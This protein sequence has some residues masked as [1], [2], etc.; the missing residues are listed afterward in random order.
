LLDRWLGESPRIRVIDEASVALVREQVRR[1]A[2]A[3]SLSKAVT[4]AAV[5]LASEL[6]HNQLAHARGGEMTIRR[7]ERAGLAGLEVIAGDRGPGIASPTEALEGTSRTVQG[8]H[9]RPGLGVGLQAVLEL[10]DETDFDV[11]IGEGTCIWARKFAERSFRRR[12]Q[13]GIYGRPYPEEE[14]SGDDGV[15]LRRDDTL[16]LAIAD[17]LGHG[18]PAREA[19]QAAIE[20]VGSS[21]DDPPEEILMRCH[22][23]LGRTRGAVMSVVRISEPGEVAAI[24]C[25]GNTSVHVYGRS[26]ARRFSGPSFVLGAPGRPPR[27]SREARTLAVDDVVVLFTDGLTTKTDLTGELDLLLRRHPI[28]IAEELVRRFGRSNDDALALVA[29]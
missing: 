21:A 6:G 26:D 11:R 29:R 23:A 19:S 20:A 1:E 10:A 27:V 5:N 22:Q 3:L 28:R 8:A 4:G 17:G 24:G 16:L 14:T 2:Q 25:A 18:P 9:K 13:V 12:R 15:F 7:I